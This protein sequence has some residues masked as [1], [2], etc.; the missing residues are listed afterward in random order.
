[1]AIPDAVGFVVRFCSYSIGLRCT[2]CDRPS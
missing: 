1:M 2:Q